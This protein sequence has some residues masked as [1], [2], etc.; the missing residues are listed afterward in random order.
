MGND[1]HKTNQTVNLQFQNKTHLFL[2]VPNNFPIPEDG[3]I[4]VPFLQAYHFNLSNKSLSLD[5]K[6]YKLE[7]E[8]I[9]LPKNTIQLITIE[10][11]KKRGD[12][13][14][15]DCPYVPDGIF[16]I[17]DYKIKV[18][19]SNPTNDS[20]SI[21]KEEINYKHIKTLPEREE[22]FSTL[23][24]EEF[25]KRL[26]LLKENVRIDHIE[27]GLKEGIEK[28]IT[29]Y[30]DVFG[31]PGDP[32]PCTNL[33]SHRI[34][35]KDNTPV[36]ERQY[37]SPEIH[38]KE[39]KN[40]VNDML[41][42]M[43]ISHSNTPYNSPLWI[44][45]KKKDASGIIKWRVVI[46]FRKLNDKT[47][48]D[49]Y[50]L[51]VIEDIIDHLGKAKYFSALDLS[52]GFHQIPMEEESKKYTGF[53]TSDGHF[54]FNRMPFGLK[55]APATF[56]RMMDTALRG[57]IGKICFA[58]LDDIVVF[59]RTIQEHNQNLV[60]LFDRLRATGLKLQPDKCEF[61]RPELEYLGH[62]ITAEGVKPNPNKI[63]AVQDFKI[64]S[65]QKQVKSF[66]GLSGYYRKFI[67]NFSTIAKPLIELTKTD[68]PFNWTDKCDESF[69]KLKKLLC[70]SPVLRYPDYDKEFTL[71]T[72]A[73]NVGLGGVLSQEGH[74]ICYIS[75]TLNKPEM[76]Y[77]TTE[78]ELLAI[79][80]AVKRLRQ[81]LLGKK[82]TIQTDHQALKWLFNVKDP[83]SRL[84]RWRLKLEEYEYVI[85]YKK[86]KENQAADALS[87]LHLT[88]EE[89][90]QLLNNEY[91][92][93]TG[94]L[95]NLENSLN[96]SG[97]EMILRNEYE[98]WKQTH[99]N[100]FIT[101]K[102]NAN[103]K[104]WTEIYK[105]NPQIKPQKTF[106]CLQQYNLDNWIYQLNLNLTEQHNRGLKVLRFHI[107]DPLFSSLEQ[108]EIKNIIN[109][110]RQRIN[111]PQ[112]A[113]NTQV[114]F[115]MT[116]DLTTAEKEAIIQE[117][118]GN[119]S[120]GHFG[121]NKTIMKAREKGIWKGMEEDIIQAV[122]KCRTCQEQKLTR[123]R[124]R[125][126][127]IIPDTPL[128]P[129]DKIAMDIFGPLPITQQGNEYILS[130][131]DVLTKYL[132]L[133]PL[134][135][136]TSESIITELLDHY[137]YIFSSPKHILTDQG[138]NFISDLV[139]KFER[140]FRIKHIK[141][142]T[143]HPQSNGSL[144]RAHAVVKDLLRT[145]IADNHTDWDLNLKI[146]C[147]AYNTTSHETTGFTPFELTFGRKANLPST[148]ATTP[149]LHQ[150]ELINLWKR[151]HE[152]YIQDAR[153]KIMKSKEKHKRIQDSRIVIP[154]EIYAPG[155]LILIHN[156]N[157][158]KGKLEQEW[159]GPA[160]ILETLE[161]ANYRIQFNNKEFLAHSN[162]L[163]PYYQ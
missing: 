122:K 31:L 129:N 59:G 108:Q 57:L 90:D 50:P 15:E 19:L 33:A 32:L 79:V 75:R 153:N 94:A 65:N 9:I 85:E 44:V 134:K 140:L 133:I 69:K 155:D 87:R 26:K 110:L 113:L 157:I 55:N 117:A 60:T 161:N 42:K 68:Q 105:E 93:D 76:N 142:T 120:T 5:N 154:Q 149:T 146:I 28:I 64:P 4:G 96:K 138:R 139:D 7:N 136:T 159:F 143:F 71:T 141:T 73:S 98:N 116:R 40:Q 89:I 95:Q 135:T 66:L 70:S 126:F 99:Q 151:R 160:I 80:W 78:K 61:L 72:D 115:S 24:I 92:G 53:S 51:P 111:E 123:I 158:R 45:P 127:A 104:L 20:I 10:A 8:I 58:Y 36:N 43:I 47:D 67:M 107:C 54:H 16:R 84:L 137:I 124:K 106:T 100:D 62:L 56:Q 14:I 17:S 128:E 125:E 162:R 29:M 13:I 102:P 103:G 6:I 63:N 38:R 27:E 83:S 3:I 132:L 144:E 131:Q 118:H 88:T 22:I 82:F 121:E 48:L 163:K 2:I 145:S 97:N 39:A 150:D 91:K 148:L 52:S 49:A 18:P 114:C 77:T 34:I 41:M 1:I 21:R 147:M 130:I 37:R 101:I 156:D 30:H 86:G 12:V 81:Y 152:K 109:F 25:S 119:L 112:E 11:D 35:L 74:P 23:S 46:D